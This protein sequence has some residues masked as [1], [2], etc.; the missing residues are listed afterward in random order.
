MS[1]AES[2]GR[3][4]VLPGGVDRGCRAGFIFSVRRVVFRN[5]RLTSAHIFMNIAELVST[6]G[7]AAVA[8]GAFF[9]GESV[10][11]LGGLA[12]QSGFLR[13]EWV[14]LTAFLGALSADQL[15]FYIGRTKGK[16]A[17]E[18]WP[19]W[20]AR[21]AKVFSM[22]DRHQVGM[23]I[24]FRFLYGLRTLAPFLIGASGIAPLRFLILNVLGAFLWATLISTLGYLFGDTIELLFGDIRHYQLL[25][26]G[27]LIGIVLAIWFVKLLRKRTGKSM[28]TGE[29]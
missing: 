12:A 21:S 22:L 3:P 9:E 25:F 28:G 16:G 29:Q 24:G 15:F 26:A 1:F 8:A 18:K 19:S 13:L 2:A 27:V 20:K 14:M 10:V 7:Y 6:Y 11:V 4:G 5:R 23:I 17:L